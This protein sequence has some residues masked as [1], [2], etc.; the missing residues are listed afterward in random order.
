[1][2]GL[3]DLEKLCAVRYGP[4]SL[5]PFL[6]YTPSLFPLPPSRSSAGAGLLFKFNT[7]H[8]GAKENIANV[9]C[10]VDLSNT[11]SSEKNV[12][13]DKYNVI[14]SARL[15]FDAGIFAATCQR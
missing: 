4:T 7:N 6:G 9:L 13:L 14:I 12:S 10:I 5:S 3:E 15:D 2:P 1:M 8:P 11:E